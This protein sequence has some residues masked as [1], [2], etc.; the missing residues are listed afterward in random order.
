MDGTRAFDL[1]K[2]IK[3]NTR[4]IITTGYAVDEKLEQLLQQGYHGFIQKPFSLH[5]FSRV[6][7]TILDKKMG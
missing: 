1:I 4:F 2:E 3:N 6:I 5:E 7:R